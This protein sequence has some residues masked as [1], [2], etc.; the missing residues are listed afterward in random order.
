MNICINK[1]MCGGLAINLSTSFTIHTGVLRFHSCGTPKYLKLLTKQ[2][3]VRNERR[4]LPFLINYTVGEQSVNVWNTMKIN[5]V[6]SNPSIFISDY[7][8]NLNF[9]SVRM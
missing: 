9:N 3:V 2:G 6:S 8:L 1:Y 4:M 7:M 5:G